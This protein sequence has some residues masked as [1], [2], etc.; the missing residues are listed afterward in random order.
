MLSGVRGRMLGA[1]KRPMSRAW[2][3]SSGDGTGSEA[4]QA[5]HSALAAR[6][7]AV[8]VK[9]TDVSG[10]CGSMFD[11]EVASPQFKGQ[12]RVKQHRMVNEILKEEI[13]SMHGLTI[14]T[15]TPEQLQNK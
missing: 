10:G 5:M 13:K 15:M 1:A 12:S 3:S 7:E 11:I 2:F 14:R 4:E 9:V 8:H 6:L